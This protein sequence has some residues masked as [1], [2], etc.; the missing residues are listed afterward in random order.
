MARRANG[1]D[2]ATYAI[3]IYC[4]IKA[5]PRAE[6]AHFTQA[7]SCAMN[8]LG[9]YLLEWCYTACRPGGREWLLTKRRAQ[10]GDHAVNGWAVDG[11]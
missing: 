4:E 7:T 5:D 11:K 3:E 10:T 6:A 2:G 8:G 1:D 9:D